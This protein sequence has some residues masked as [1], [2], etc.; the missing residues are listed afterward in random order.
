VECDS[1]QPGSK[2]GQTTALWDDAFGWRERD[3]TRDATPVRPGRL[4]AARLHQVASGCIR[5][6]QVVGGNGLGIN[7]GARESTRKTVQTGCPAQG[8]C[9]SPERLAGRTRTPLQ[10]GGA[11]FDTQSAH[12]SAGHGVDS[13]PADKG[14]GPV[15]HLSRTRQATGPPVAHDLRAS[16]RAKLQAESQFN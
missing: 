9:A 15:P 8:Y 5:L 16:P 13:A 4:G 1:G 2:V 3:A 10:G 14:V 7:C 6:H 11:G 12:E